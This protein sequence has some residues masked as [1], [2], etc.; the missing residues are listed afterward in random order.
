MKIFT[1]FTPRKKDRPKRLPLITLQEFADK[2]GV[3]Y[4][5]LRKKGGL[6][7]EELKTGVRATKKYY[8][9]HVLEE[10]F[11]TLEWR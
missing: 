6:P 9:Q 2:K 5:T 1:N 3:N 10:W 8:K 7:K 4:N 11:E